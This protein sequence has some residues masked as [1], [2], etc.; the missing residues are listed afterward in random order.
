MYVCGKNFVRQ[1]R[2]NRLGDLHETRTGWQSGGGVGSL[3][4]FWGIWGQGGP[5]GGQRSP[6]LT[7]GPDTKVCWNE[8]VAGP[9]LGGYGHASWG[10]WRAGGPTKMN[11]PRG[12]PEGKAQKS[13]VVGHLPFSENA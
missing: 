13:K 9:R 12:P 8:V 2:P 11:F 7:P 10:P 5:R 3:M 4:Q 6:G 1:S